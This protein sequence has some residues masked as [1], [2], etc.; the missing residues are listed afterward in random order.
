[1]SVAMKLNVPIKFSII[2]W[3]IFLIHHTI[4][5]VSNFKNRLI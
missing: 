3:L 1:M 4:V 5:Q 2:E